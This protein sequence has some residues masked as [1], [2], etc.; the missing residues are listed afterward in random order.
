M[1]I[2]IFT[3]SL[4]SDWNHGNAHF[5]RG[6]A[7][8]LVARGCEVRI[9]EPRDG[10]SRQNLVSEFGIAPLQAFRRKFP[11][12]QSTLY[13]LEDLNL[14]PMLEGADIVLVH[15]WN[16]PELIARIGEHRCSQGGYRLFYHD[17]HHRT[18]SAPETVAALNLK[19]YDGVLAYG[20]SIRDVYQTRFG[21]KNAWTWHEAAD[22]R[23]FRPE[24]APEKLGDVVWIGNWGDEE[25]TEE[26]REFLIKPVKRMGLRAAVY[27]VRYPQHAVEEL[28]AAGIE[29]CGWLPNYRVPAVF[30][31]YWVTL[32][33]PRRVY[34]R[35]LPGIPTIRPFEALACGIPLI[36]APW[37]DTENLFRP[38]DFLT[39][40]DGD[41]AAH[42]IGCL[43][44]NEF[45]A[46]R[47]TRHGLET[48][49][50][51][52]TCGHRVDELFSIAGKVAS[53]RPA[54]RIA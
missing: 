43:M 23:T 16:P 5:L 3:H 18:V 20:A 12:L 47:M 6:I 46:K 4:V 7:L 26:L 32:H 30:S 21:V 41:E 36:C 33:I 9:F 2:V 53:P 34:A 14:D 49:R 50:E 19:H 11:V 52:H 48:I 39:V 54:E 44:A 8:E 1:R 17:T 29:Y 37:G 28:A 13:D 38:G 42:Q 27:G 22:V 25:R 35:T 31:R 10:W 45:V 24:C 15:E 51:R 40:R